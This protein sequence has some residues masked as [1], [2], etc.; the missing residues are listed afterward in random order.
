MSHDLLFFCSQIHTDILGSFSKAFYLIIVKRDWE[1]QSP[2][3][4]KIKG[5]EISSMW[6]KGSEISMPW[7]LISTI[8]FVRHYFY[9]LYHHSN[10]VAVLY[11]FFNNSYYHSKFVAPFALCFISFIQFH[12]SNFSLAF[13]NFMYNSCRSVITFVYCADKL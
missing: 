12:C 1:F 11:V 3:T 13:H 7:F 5:L 8:A 2:K 4:N 9:S 10:S 6:D